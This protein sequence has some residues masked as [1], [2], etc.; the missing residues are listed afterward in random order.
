MKPPIKAL[1][2]LLSLC[3]LLS[4]CDDDDEYPKISI[5]TPTTEVTFSTTASE[6]VI[7]GTVSFPGS[8]AYIGGKVYATNLRTGRRYEADLPLGNENIRWHV[9]IPDLQ[10]GDNEIVATVLSANDFRETRITIVRTP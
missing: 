3:V 6:L 8:M 5:D 10:P 4:A 2:L 9:F 1:I 7:G